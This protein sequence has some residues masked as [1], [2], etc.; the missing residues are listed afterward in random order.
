MRLFIRRLG[1]DMAEK[2]F[3]TP[4]HFAN[5]VTK[6]AREN[7]GGFDPDKT[8]PIET[9]VDM[10][11][12]NGLGDEYGFAI[13]KNPRLLEEDQ[14]LRWLQQEKNG[15]FVFPSQIELV[16]T[17]EF[18]DCLAS[19]KQRPG[20]Y[21]FW[22][23]NDLPLYVGTSIDLAS[24]IC[25]SFSE[26]FRHYSSVVFL[27]YVVT[28]TAS[29]AALCEV[30]LIAKHKPALN[31]ACKFND[32]LTIEVNIP[33]LSDRIQCNVPGPKAWIQNGDYSGVMIPE[34]RAEELGIEL[35]KPRSGYAS[36][37]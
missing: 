7:P 8:M 1:V 28:A 33:A 5:M 32:E 35:S 26:R 36:V 6:I 20:C 23:E 11:Y 16:T 34:D 14:F 17:N 19:L 25:S 30:A 29:D 18:R 24:R 10:A 22:N 12:E 31:G 15:G 13:R 3:K 37:G 27:R 9:Y 4:R 21:T 2:Y